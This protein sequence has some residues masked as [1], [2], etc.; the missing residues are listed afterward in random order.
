MLRPF[1]KP[2]IIMTPKSLLRHPMAKSSA[3][4][5]T[6]QSHFKRILSDR[7]EIADDKVRRLILCSGK[8]AYDLMEAR[9]EAKLGD[10]SIV[11]LEQLYPFPGEPLAARL[12][13]MS[14]LQQVVWCQEEPKNNG[15]WFFVES[16]IEEA[17]AQAGHKGMRPC[18]AGRDVAA[19]PATGLAKTHAAQQQ[20]LVALALGLGD[21][22]AAKRT[23]K[24]AKKGS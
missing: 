11:R 20:A 22:D 4:E 13:R 16:R 19:S 7:M 12:M 14:N 18:Y 1:R 2:L 23:L 21:K 6:E 5:F 17:L 3:T 15:A 9:A 8:V 24:T 10:V